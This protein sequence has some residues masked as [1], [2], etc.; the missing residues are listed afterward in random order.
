[1]SCVVL[2]SQYNESSINFD[3]S[4]RAVRGNLFLSTEIMH[5]LLAYVMNENCSSDCGSLEILMRGN[6]SFETCWL[7]AFMETTFLCR[8]GSVQ[9][10]VAYCTRL[11]WHNT[12]KRFEIL[13]NKWYHLL[14]G[15]II[16]TYLDTASFSYC[17]DITMSST[18]IFDTQHY[19]H[20]TQSQ[21]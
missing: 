10:A 18:R 3:D 8:G 19:K 21:P 16:R 9:P 15:R 13:L 12:V 6:V 11:Q 7:S 14:S 4:S 20:V 17:Y 1:M 5:S 2:F